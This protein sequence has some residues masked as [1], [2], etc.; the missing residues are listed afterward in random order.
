MDKE[1]RNINHYWNYFCSLCSKLEKTKQYI[2]HS[3]S[4]HMSVYSFEFQQ[5][6]ILAAVE[7]ENISKQLCL[8]IDS[9][10]DTKSDIIKITEKITSKYP[11][12]TETEIMTDY[13]I[14]KPLKGWRISN[15]SNNN[16]S[17]NG[18]KWW[19]AYN[20]IKHKGFK[21]FNLATLENAINA[22]ASLLVLE[23][24]LMYNHIGQLFQEKSCEYF[25]TKYQSEYL[26]TEEKKLPDF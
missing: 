18:L 13:E 23:L 1:F 17:L 25:T 24:Y 16:K 22:T 4:N 15:N 19:E 8:T 12:I 9:T 7:F 5:I 21:N 11:K 20:K 26:I 10:F 3:N 6:I 14:L 2:D